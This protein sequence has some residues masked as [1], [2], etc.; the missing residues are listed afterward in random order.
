MT[1]DPTP[2]EA[3]AAI[4]TSRSALSERIRPLLGEE[5]A[6]AMARAGYWPP[7]RSPRRGDLCS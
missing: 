2:Q 3:L 1:Q 4:Q 5:I 7:L 6:L